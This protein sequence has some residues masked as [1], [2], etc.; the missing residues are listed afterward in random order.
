MSGVCLRPI[1]NNEPVSK[2]KRGNNYVAPKSPGSPEAPKEDATMDG[3]VAT[4]EQISISLRCKETAEQNMIK[5]KELECKAEK[6]EAQMS[7]THDTEEKHIVRLKD[8]EAEVKKKTLDI[9]DLVDIM[10]SS[11]KQLDGVNYHNKAL[12]QLK[13]DLRTAIAIEEE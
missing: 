13:P 7:I 1:L 10:R 4:A 5:Q 12:P 8:L 9:V 3:Q 2:W 11:R 6:V